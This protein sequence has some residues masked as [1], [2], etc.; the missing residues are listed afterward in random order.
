MA[1]SERIKDTP[2]RRPTG[3]P[4]S[5]GALEDYLESQPG[6]EA[7]AFYAMLHT[8]G[9]SGRRVYEAVQAEAQELHNQGNLEAAAIYANMGQQTVNRHR[10]RGCRCFK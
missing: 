9:W 4:C 8:L 3:L 5:V 6:A 2:A 1:L 10:S 7:D